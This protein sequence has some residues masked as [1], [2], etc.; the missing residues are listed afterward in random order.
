L[1]NFNP[2]KSNVAALKAHFRPVSDLKPNPRNA[3][4]HSKHQIRQI[5]ES[6]RAFGFTN[7]V[8]VDG[9]DQILAG[10]GR[11]EAAKLLGM[12]RIP[13]IRIE[14]LTDE[15]IRAFVIAD[16]RLAEKAGWDTEILAIELQAL[17]ELDCV[18]F[19]ITITGFEVPEIDLI[20]EEANAS[21]SIEEAPPEPDFTQEPI[22]KSGDLWLLNK[23][24]IVCGNALHESTYKTLMGNRR[25]AA[26]FTDPPYNVRID[27]HATGNGAIRHRE[28]AMASGELSEAEFVSFLT[29]AVQLLL[30]L[31]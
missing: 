5:A 28:F 16:N 17:L 21:P 6:I 4:T 2:T 30:M 9:R 11:V 23:H 22:T 13:T 7:P 24:R 19:D 29:N 8:L 25:A 26:A 1:T 10:H 15:Q 14:S 27:G 20:I 12:D 3:R 31:D 18:D